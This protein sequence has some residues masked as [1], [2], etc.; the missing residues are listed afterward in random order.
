MNALLKKAFEEVAGLPDSKQEAIASLILKEIEDERG[1]DD[2]F[3]RSEDL[4]GDMVRLAR[5]EVSEG[6]TT[7]YDP[8]DRPAK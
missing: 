1:W 5:M 8:S 3:A 4:L 7:P 6:E 2:R